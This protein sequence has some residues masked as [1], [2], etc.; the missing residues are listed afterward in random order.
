MLLLKASKNANLMTEHYIDCIVLLFNCFSKQVKMLISRPTRYQC[1]IL[2]LKASK[3]VDVMTEH[4]IH[5]IVLF[6]KASKN[7]D[8]MMEHII[9][10]ITLLLKIAKKLISWQNI[11]F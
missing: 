3:N 5:S 7:A 6:L 8:I 11:I 9:H 2:L 10:C 1:N 4:I